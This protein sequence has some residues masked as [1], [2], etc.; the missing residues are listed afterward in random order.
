M[1]LALW[2]PW[3]RGKYLLFHCDNESVVHIMAKASTCSKTMMAL[4]HTFTLL[5]MQHNMQVHTQHIAMV[6]NDVADVLSHFKMDRFWQLCPHARARTPYTGQHLVALGGL[7][8]PFL[9]Q[10]YPCWLAPWH[11][12]ALPPHAFPSLLQGSPPLGS[13]GCPCHYFIS[14]FSA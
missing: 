14:P 2:G 12:H 8:C 13:D 11:S 10:G 1:A 7:Q 9:L 5:A 4:D 6:C 3:L